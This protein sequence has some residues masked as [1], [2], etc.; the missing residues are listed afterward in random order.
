MCII[1]AFNRETLF[2][3]SFRALNM[4]LLRT[5]MCHTIFSSL[6]EVTK[7]DARWSYQWD[8][9]HVHH[10]FKFGRLAGLV[11]VLIMHPCI[12]AKPR[13]QWLIQQGGSYGHRLSCRA[14]GSQ[15]GA[16]HI[17]MGL[18]ETAIR[19]SR[20]TWFWRAIHA[21]ISG[22]YL[23]GELWLD[24]NPLFSQI[25]PWAWMTREIYLKSV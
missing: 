22:P 15:P 18:L 10:G 1:L 12:Q 19:I 24:N 14:T 9:E 20:A 25:A 6:K 13:V 3:V 8:T 21:M 7:I 11:M 2:W 17:I 5:S 4:Y 16:S 23:I